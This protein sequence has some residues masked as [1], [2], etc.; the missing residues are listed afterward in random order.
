MQKITKIKDIRRELAEER[1]KGRSIG[2]VPT[3]GYFHH[4]HI[5]LMEKAKSE[6]D[7]VVV[8]IFVNPTQFSPEEDYESYPRDLDKD[9]KIANDAGVDYIFDPNSDEMYPHGFQTSVDV[10]KLSK[11]L[12]GKK[13]VSHFQGV[14]T[15]VLK[16]FNIVEPDRIYFGLKDYQQFRIIERMVADLNIEIE[17]RALPTVRDE[18]GL[19]TSSRNSYLTYDEREQATVLYE[20]LT[21][22]SKL[23]EDGNTNAKDLVLKMTKM[24]DKRPLIQLEYIEIVDKYS[25]EPIETVQEGKTLIAITAKTGKARLIDNIEV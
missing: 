25:F 9:S 16:L 22:A 2:F 20:A 23:F 15:I 18:D 1:K 11:L 13:R 4:G 17:L 21:K 14:T 24:L 19:A 6:N 8:S 5:S 10:E 7:I 3:M 12:C